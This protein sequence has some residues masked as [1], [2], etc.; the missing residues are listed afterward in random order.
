[1]GRNLTTAGP[2]RFL[3]AQ[4]TADVVQPKKDEKKHPADAGKIRVS[5]PNTYVLDTLSLGSLL[6]QAFDVSQV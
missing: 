1:V 2:S 4:I 5:T 3:F 6:Q